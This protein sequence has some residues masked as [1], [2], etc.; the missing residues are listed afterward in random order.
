MHEAHR[1]RRETQAAE[2]AERRQAADDALD[3]ARAQSAELAEM[4]DLACDHLDIDP[5][6]R[7]NPHVRTENQSTVDHEILM[8]ILRRTIET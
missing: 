1:R 4:W 6:R 8:T 5:A 2:R 7:G 3:R